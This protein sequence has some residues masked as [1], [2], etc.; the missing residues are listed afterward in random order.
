M[1]R[2]YRPTGWT[3]TLSGNEYLHLEDDATICW[4]NADGYLL[5]ADFQS[6]GV[7]A[8]DYYS[9]ACNSCS[10]LKDIE[11]AEAAIAE[12]EAAIAASEITIEE[13]AAALEE[14]SG[15]EI[16]FEDEPVDA[17]EPEEPDSEDK[18]PRRPRRK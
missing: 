4:R 3:K 2:Y 15:L 11:K 13:V 12:I 6:T 18:K 17:P 10:G 5:D 7:R 16:V 9:P 14:E 1:S 8:P